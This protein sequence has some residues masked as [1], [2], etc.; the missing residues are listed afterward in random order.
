MSSSSIGCRRCQKRQASGNDQSDK[1]ADQKEPAIGRKR[2]Q[3]N[4]NDC[5]G[6]DEANRASQ[7]EA[8]SGARLGFHGTILEKAAKM[9]TVEDP[10]TAWP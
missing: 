6:D 5:D 1:Y 8:E 10:A 3:E 4:C 9:F 7:S 2:N